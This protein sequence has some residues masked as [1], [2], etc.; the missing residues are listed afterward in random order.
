[1]S[2]KGNRGAAAAA[3]VAT[4]AVEER[5]AEKN[6]AS[7]SV[8]GICWLQ[9]TASSRQTTTFFTLRAKEDRQQGRTREDDRFGEGETSTTLFDWRLIVAFKSGNDIASL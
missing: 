1:M 4:R 6:A 5:E 8:A 3:A 2:N 7:G 9:Q